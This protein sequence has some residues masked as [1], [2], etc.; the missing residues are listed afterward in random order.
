MTM[1]V[2]GPGGQGPSHGCERP[3]LT[4]SLAMTGQPYLAAGCPPYGLRLLG[5]R[6]GQ[7]LMG[8]RL[9]GRAE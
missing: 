7:L 4:G 1:T 8:L 2:K 6:A 9:F 3:T 5:L